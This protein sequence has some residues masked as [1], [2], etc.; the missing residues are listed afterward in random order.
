MTRPLLGVCLLLPLLAG[1]GATPGGNPHFTQ[2]LRQA[3]RTQGDATCLSFYPPAA[4]QAGEEGTTT[5]DIGIGPNGQITSLTVQV[6]SGKSRLDQAALA[7]L[8]AWRWSPAMLGDAAIESHVSQS[9]SW[10]LK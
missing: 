9:I 7:C 6:S 4:R 8:R 1:C 2:T 10:R 3:V 5:V